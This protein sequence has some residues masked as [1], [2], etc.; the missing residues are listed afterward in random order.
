MSLQL[1]MTVFSMI[2]VVLFIHSFPQGQEEREDYYQKW[3]DE[4]VIY[5]IIAEERAVFEMLTSAEEK[6]NFIEQFWRRRDT[7]PRTAYNEFKEEHYRRIAYANDH[8]KSGIDGWTTDRG[9]IYIT[10]GPPTSIERHPTGGTYDRP[11]AEGG[12]ST[13]TFPY[14]VWYYQYIEG[15]GSG[16]EIEFVDPIG[17][18][19][20]R[21][22]LRATEKDALLYVP[23]AGNTLFEEMG[24][25]TR[26]G[27][28]RSSMAMRS[29]GL[30][31]D[32]FGDPTA[33]PFEKLQRYV[34]LTRPPAI[35]FTGL[36]TIV[37]SN[38]YYDSLPFHF[39]YDVFRYSTEKALC[40][41]T[42]EIANKQLGR[43]RSNIQIYVEVEDLSRRT[44]YEFE[45]VIYAEVS[46]TNAQGKSLY[47]KMVPIEPGRYKISV[48]VKDVDRD[49]IG[50]LE[51]LFLVP[52]QEQGLSSSTLIL[53]SQIQA[54]A[55][56]EMPPDP[57]VTLGG[58]KIYP[59]VQGRLKVD[60]PVGIYL[61][62][63]NIQVDQASFTPEVDV[64]YEIRR[65]PTGEILRKGDI[66]SHSIAFFA[67]RIGIA[68][69]WTDLKLPPGEYVLGLH[70]KD[71]ISQD[72]ISPETVFVLE[73]SPERE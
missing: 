59:N 50:T 62:V 49:K 21:I 15:I 56:G 24:V 1:K 65:S 71:L 48:V 31:G 67:D 64:S 68:R 54:A 8:F 33:N 18:G 51:T 58:L 45:D 66:T 14:E 40:P 3:L 39:R 10:H 28:I 4:H 26:A 70:I 73:D 46:E 47:Q 7:D 25:E 60:D 27:R 19:E 55:S 53:A 69:V 9:Q 20:Y 30:Q 63:Y 43:G 61:E 32:S 23:G 17:T 5:I 11:V 16:I 38:I 52:S 57:F 42:I 34:D 6:E 12:G 41:I 72:T 22:A 37:E 29:L 2:F 44:V 13:T 36:K 35:E